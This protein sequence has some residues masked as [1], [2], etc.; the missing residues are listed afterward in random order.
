MSTFSLNCSNTVSL[1]SKA[2]T[3]LTINFFLSSGMVM[4]MTS[5]L[6]LM[7][8]Q[9]P[10]ILSFVLGVTNPGFLGIVEKL[11]P[12]LSLGLGQIPALLDPLHVALEELGLV[13]VLQNLGSLFDQLIDYIPLGVELD[14]GLLL[15]LDELIDILHAGGS[16]VA[17]GGEHDAIKE[18]NMGL[19]LIT[20]GV[21]LPVQVNHDLGLH[22]GGDQFFVLL[23]Q[24]VKK[25]HFLG[26]LIF[27]SLCH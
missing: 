5:T 7:A 8:A 18:L 26:A 4:F 13:R 10:I 20:V 6:W 16:N 22:D 2:L 1:S 21:A 27:C 15:P 14:K 12:L 24:V 9:R 3:S 23:D 19:Q 11:E 25:S 17:G